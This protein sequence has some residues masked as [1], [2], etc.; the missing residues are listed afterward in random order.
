MNMNFETFVRENNLLQIPVEEAIKRYEA[1][2]SEKTVKEDERLY[3]EFK[4]KMLDKK[5]A[6]L[7]LIATDEYQSMKKF[8]N[9]IKILES[10]PIAQYYYFEPID[11]PVFTMSFYKKFMSFWAYVLDHDYIP[12]Y[13]S[14]MDD[15]IVFKEFV[16]NED[17]FNNFDRLF[18]HENENEINQK[19]EFLKRFKNEYQK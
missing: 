15:E 9:E 5:E 18:F 2:L 13:S 11:L 16:K 3:Q 14:G 7:K 8:I 17:F 19:M 12:I 4:Q 1:N 10:K 6:F